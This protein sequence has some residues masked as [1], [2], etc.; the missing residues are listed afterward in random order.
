MDFLRGSVQEVLFTSFQNP[1][2]VSQLSI[3]LTNSQYKST[4]KE[5][6]FVLARRFSPW[7]L[8]PVALCL[9]QHNRSWWG[10]DVRGGRPVHLVVAGNKKERHGEV[11][12]LI[13]LIT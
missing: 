10:A 6:K 9:W 2:L 13:S 12:V 11:R 7:M 5:E 1:L 3:A 8:S 4:Y